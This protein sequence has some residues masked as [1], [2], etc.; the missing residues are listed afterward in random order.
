L[1]RAAELLAGRYSLVV[2]N[3]PYL[4]RGKQDDILKE[5][6]KTQYPLGKADLATAFVLRCLEFCPQGG[7]MALVTPQNWLFLTTYT[8]LREMLLDRREWNIVARLGPG[9]FETIGGHVVNVTMI[10]LTAAYPARQ[11]QHQVDEGPRKGA[12]TPHPRVPVVLE[13]GRHAG[14]RWRPFSRV[15]RRAA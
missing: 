14:L 10:G 7:S 8:K 4:G 1:A 11:A 6:L 13:L 9:A 5:H 3:V 15:H 2:T 12:Q